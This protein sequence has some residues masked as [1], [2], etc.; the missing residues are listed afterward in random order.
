MILLV[1]Q[2]YTEEL[3]K[4]DLQKMVAGV[5]GCW[6]MESGKIQFLRTRAESPGC[7]TWSNR[8][9]LHRNKGEL[10]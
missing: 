9:D 6:G 3:Y 10:S 8:G 7:L 5:G 1:M 4:K 2:E